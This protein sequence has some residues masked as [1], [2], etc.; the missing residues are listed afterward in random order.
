MALLQSTLQ[1]LQCHTCGW[2]RLAFFSARVARASIARAVRGRNP[3]T[4]RGSGKAA[5]PPRAANAATPRG[6]KGS[7]VSSTVPTAGQPPPCVARP[8]AQTELG[9]PAVSAPGRGGNRSDS[10]RLA[11]SD[12][13]ASPAWATKSPSR[14]GGGTA[15]AAQ[16]RGAGT[17]GTA[18]PTDWA[19]VATATRP[20][21]AGGVAS[22]VCAT[23]VGCPPGEGVCEPVGRR[24]IRDSGLRGPGDGGEEAIALA[25]EGCLADGKLLE[26]HGVA[27][28]V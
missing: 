28:C 8:P 20:G 21:D 22:V 2:R 4:C 13:T 15:T 3:A 12:E 5:P 14:P 17:D 18:P 1:V 19:S 23:R 9:G 24:G 7:D 25:T 11:A 27:G 26:P 16:G 6:A 10:G